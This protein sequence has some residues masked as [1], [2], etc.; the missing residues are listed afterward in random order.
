MLRDTTPT[1][2]VVHNTDTASSGDDKGIGILYWN[3]TRERMWGVMLGR[4]SRNRM[5][6]AVSDPN[7]AA[8]QHDDIFS[9][10]VIQ[11]L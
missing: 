3:A 8:V 1:T 5:M 11:K 2:A 10:I 6:I 9:P 7:G 4:D